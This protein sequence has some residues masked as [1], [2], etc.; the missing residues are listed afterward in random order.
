MARKK[1]ALFMMVLL[2][3]LL[4]PQQVMGAAPYSPSISLE[5]SK[6][7][8]NMGE[9]FTVTVKGSNL[10]DVYAYQLNL[11]FNPNQLKFKLGSESTSI[12][13]F[14]TPVTFSEEGGTHL[15]FA[16]TKSG[17]AAGDSGAQDLATFTFT[18]TGYGSASVA[19]KDTLLID[20]KESQS[21]TSVALVS[22]SIVTTG[23]EGS[24]SGG[25]NGG[26][27][28][29]SKEDIIAAEGG[30]LTLHGATI[31]VPVGALDNDI[32]VSVAK[33]SDIS[34]LPVDS[35]LKLISDVY[36]IKKDKE[37]EFKKL[38]VITL[39]FDKTAVDF[40]KSF[41]GVYWLNEQTH[42]WVL[43]DDLH[44]DQVNGTASGSVKHFTKFAVLI[45]TKKDSD[46]DETSFAD[47][48]GH[49]AETSIRELIKLGA[50]NGYPDNSFKP[51][52]KIT[53]AEFVAVIVKALNLKAQAALNF[54]DMSAH[55]AKNEIA[56]AAALGVV[57]GYTE[58]AFGPDDV[59]TREQMAAIVIRA[60]QI[61][62]VSKNIDV[63][64]SSAISD[65]AR[66]ALATAMAK[67]LVDGYEDHTVKPQANTSRAE[68]AT[69]I[70]RALKLT[71]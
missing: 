45:S 9:E 59:L 57:N 42:T 71:K 39:L 12:V 21:T 54:D 8:L 67:G 11:Y 10:E 31:D 13:G 47:I 34:M 70:L 50:I 37:G 2:F 30:A 3:I 52:N 65:W 17:K 66:T 22:T 32:K 64:D 69:V 5:A 43:L 49:W 48:K 63:T 14:S 56:I 27:G 33:V 1:Q 16:H 28:T 62:P 41:V 7:V 24:S 40:T 38:V 15:V 29:P 51:D 6:N 23:D 19:L 36:E 61:D 20:S 46:L 58:Q 25:G 18:T 4:L 26:G 53:R 60:A 55:W 35:S 44:V 68:A